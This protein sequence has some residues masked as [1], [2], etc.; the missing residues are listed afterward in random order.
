MLVVATIG[1]VLLIL[2]QP[3]AIIRVIRNGELAVVKVFRVTRY[4]EPRRFWS[5]I[6]GVVIWLLLTDALLIV[7]IY[8]AAR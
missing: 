4:S 5:I 8:I 7:Q 3:F 1:L 6:A 2:V